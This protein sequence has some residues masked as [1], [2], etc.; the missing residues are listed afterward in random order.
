[1]KSS[2][3]VKQQIQAR[4]T[5][6]SQDKTKKILSILQQLN[7]IV[8]IA[9]FAVL[10]LG[11][12]Q[13]AQLGS[14]VHELRGVVA[15]KSNSIQKIVQ[16]T[17]TTSI[18]PVMGKN[19]VENLEIEEEEVQKI[20]KLIG[21]NILDRTNGNLKSI[22]SSHSKEAQSIL[23]KLN[24]KEVKNNELEDLL[25]ATIALNSVL[26][27]HLSDHIYLSRKEEQ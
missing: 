1:M 9:L 27:K 24:T 3:I 17:N 23:A 22:F 2:T 18:S 14:E 11:Y 6:Q 5:S 13:F 10:V 7:A 25:V 12:I 16:K 8:W 19:N 20:S 21:S 4:P 26:D 15:E